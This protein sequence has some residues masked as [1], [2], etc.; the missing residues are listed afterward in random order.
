[1]YFLCG[2]YYGLVFCWQKYIEY[3]IWWNAFIVQV[4]KLYCINN[5]LFWHPLVSHM[6]LFALYSIVTSNLWIYYTQVQFSQF[7]SHFCKCLISVSNLKC[8]SFPAEVVIKKN[9]NCDN[10]SIMQLGLYFP[11][12]EICTA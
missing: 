2:C 8:Q 4:N 3:I 7:Y 12:D 5:L 6:L 9:N 10:I 1:M 11:F